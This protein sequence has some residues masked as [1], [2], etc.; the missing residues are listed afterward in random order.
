[1]GLHVIDYYRQKTETDVPPEPAWG[2]TQLLHPVDDSPF[3][4]DVPRG[5]HVLGVSCAMYRAPCHPHTM[6]STDFILIHSLDY[7]HA[8]LRPCDTTLTVGQEIPLWEVRTFLLVVQCTRFGGS[9][10]P[11]WVAGSVASNQRRE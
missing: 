3:V 1:M 6:P 10:A 2:E 4:G 11:L 7:T 8:T 5:Q 9:H